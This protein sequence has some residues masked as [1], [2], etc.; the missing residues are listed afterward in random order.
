MS[1]FLTTRKRSGYYQETRL[2]DRFHP[3]RARA[4]T[5]VPSASITKMLPPRTNAICLPS[6]DQHGELLLSNADVRQMGK[7]RPVCVYHGDLTLGPPPGVIRKG[8]IVKAIRL[9]SGDQDGLSLATDHLS[10]EQPAGS[11]H[12]G[13]KRYI[14]GKSY[15]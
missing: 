14:F 9:P 10:G 6:G 2:G 13:V 8:L 11:P 12:Q 3:P 7:A 4:L 5:F 1:S 15:P